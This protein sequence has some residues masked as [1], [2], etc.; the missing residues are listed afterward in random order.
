MTRLHWIV[1]VGVVL[2]LL[3]V[4]FQP[5][6]FHLTNLT[7]VDDGFYY[8]GYARNIALG[9]GPTFDGLVQTN[10]VQPLWAL[11]LIGVATIAPD[12][13]IL[14]RASMILAIGLAV[15]STFAM[16]AILMQLFA[17]SLR[18]VMLLLYLALI[19]SPQLVLSGMETPANPAMF[20]LS[21]AALLRIRTQAWKATSAAGILVGLTC[22]A[23]VDNLVL[24]PAFAL[25]LICRNGTLIILTT[26]GG[27][28]DA[29]R[30]IIWLAVPIILIVCAYVAFNVSAFGHAL[31]I[32]GEIK[33]TLQSHYADALGGRFSPPYLIETTQAA[34]LHYATIINSILTMLLISFSPLTL[35]VRGALAL[36]LLL[37]VIVIWKRRK[38]RPPMQE[39]QPSFSTIIMGLVILNV[40]F[41]TWLLFFQLGKRNAS[42]LNWYYVP[43]YI[44]IT[45]LLGL[46]LP[47]IEQLLKTDSGRSYR[48]ATIVLIASM[49]VSIGMFIWHFQHPVGVQ[50]LLS[51]YRAT[52]WAN[53][54]VPDDDVIGSFNAGVIGYFS[55]AVVINLD[56]L[57]NDKEILAIALGKARLGEYIIRHNIRWV[58]DYA[59]TNWS[60][61]AADSFQGIPAHWLEPVYSQDFDNY[62]FVPST[63]YVFKVSHGLR[64]R[65][66]IQR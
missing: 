28:G 1:L 2:F 43:E 6:E 50:P 5:V 39:S 12:H 16:N 23:R 52:E 65:N 45:V 32:S 37:L 19:S 64:P 42:V 30:S 15:I 63:F 61:H 60:A 48:I 7:W 34:I 38:L 57:M 53:E 21:L 35:I 25:I 22:L 17:P 66:L 10:G 55:E 51:H 47:R 33:S 26:R 49:M 54:H 58:M 24:A 59:G 36:G 27:L 41:H 40:L 62:G 11:L 46:I 14:M 9:N 4:T 29:I 13:E 31:P 20:T 44:L 56:G 8:L 3:L 18:S